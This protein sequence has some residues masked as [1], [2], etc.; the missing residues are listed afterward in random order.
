MSAQF[1]WHA[2]EGKTAQ[3]AGNSP[4]MVHKNYKGLLTKTEA[5]KWFNVK[6]ARPANVVVLKKPANA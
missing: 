6:P 5:K 1:A 2:D 4:S 3:Q